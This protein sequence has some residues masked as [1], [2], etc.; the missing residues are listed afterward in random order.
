[1]KKP[2]V[3]NS[4]EVLQ[5]ID[6]DKPVR[7]YRNLH[8]KCLSVQQKGIVRCHV[9]NIVLMDVKFLVSKAG[10][11]KVR[12]EKKKQ[13]HAYVAGTVVDSRKTLELLDCGWSEVIYN[14]Y[15]TDYFTCK[16]SGRYID[17]AWFA[18]VDA[19]GSMLAFGAMYKC[20]T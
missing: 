13:V 15:Y 3:K 4:H 19:E 5:Y 6:A 16:E 7:V 2:H 18:D 14:P 8:K 20:P 17:T 9:D 10:Q 11:Q 12:D 1:M